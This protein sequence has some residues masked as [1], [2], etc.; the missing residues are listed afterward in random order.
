MKTMIAVDALAA[1][2]ADLEGRQFVTDRRSTQG[3]GDDQNLIVTAN[4]DESVVKVFYL[5]SCEGAA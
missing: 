2:E 1:V 3:C 5:G 4:A